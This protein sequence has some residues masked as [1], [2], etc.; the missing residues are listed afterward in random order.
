MLNKFTAAKIRSTDSYSPGGKAG[1]R[2]D[3]ATIVYAN[4]IRECW[5]DIPVI[6]GG[7]EA[8][9]RRLAHYDYWS[10]SVRRSI[11]DSRADLLIHGMGAADCFDCRKIEPGLSIREIHDVNG[12]RWLTGDRGEVPA[13]SLEVASYEQVSVNKTDYAAAF[14]TQYLEQD[15]DLRSTDCPNCMAIGFWCRTSGIA[16]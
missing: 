3:R 12:T 16:A 15:P 14:K 13:N 5:P 9:L 1:L 8:S 10:D 7:I 11:I 4:R 2:P 6:I